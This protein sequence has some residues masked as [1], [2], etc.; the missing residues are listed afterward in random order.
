MDIA[1]DPRLPWYSAIEKW[2]VKYAATLVLYSAYGHNF[3]S[4]SLQ[5]LLHFDS[6]VI[7]SGVVGHIDGAIFRRWKSDDGAFSEPISDCMRYS[8]WLQ[9]KRCFKLCD[10]NRCPKLG[11]RDYDPAYKY[12]YAYK[13]VIHNLNAFTYEADA[14]LCGD[15]TSMAH[16]GYG[17][18]GGSGLNSQIYNKPG[19]TCGI[20]TVL[21]CDATRKRP[22]AYL[23]RHNLHPPFEDK[24]QDKKDGWTMNGP[25]EVRR[26]VDSIESL[27]KGSFQNEADTR[28]QI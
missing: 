1:E 6:I 14:D 11:E 26:I 28:R 9:I 25:K 7:K 13:A 5:E 16:M 27:I 15:E 23:H 18:G 4:V 19:I 24:I 8:R 17:E 21:L 10:N 12:D 2:T 20:Q 3:E 22:R